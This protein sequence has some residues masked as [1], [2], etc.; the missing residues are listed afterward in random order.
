MET[1]IWLL[2]FSPPKLGGVRGGISL[3]CE[4]GACLP[5]GRLERVK[6]VIN[7]LSPKIIGGSGGKKWNAKNVITQEK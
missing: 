5:V 6:L 7:L 2:N 4:G 3:P 1:A